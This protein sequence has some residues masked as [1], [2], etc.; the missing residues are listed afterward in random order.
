[1]VD[2][3]AMQTAWCI[4]TSQAHYLTD[5]YLL[6]GIPAAAAA[7]LGW[8][9]PCCGQMLILPLATVGSVVNERD[10]LSGDLHYDGYQ[11]ADS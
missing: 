1:M 2:V 4:S 6:L 10:G 8:P 9:L 7:A 11:Q 3:S 5:N